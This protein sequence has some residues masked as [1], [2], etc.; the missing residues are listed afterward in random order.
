MKLT[1][2]DSAITTETVAL[3]G[4]SFTELR[5]VND[6][7]F[8]NCLDPAN[9]GKSCVLELVGVQQEGIKSGSVNTKAVTPRDANVRSAVHEYG[10][11]SFLPLV[12]LGDGEVKILYTDYS[13]QHRLF[14]STALDDS[15]T[16]EP[17]VPISTPP[18]TRFAD[19]FHDKKRCR[20][21]CVMEDHS[22]P[23]PEAV[24]NCIVSISLLDLY[25]EDYTHPNSSNRNMLV[26]AKGNDFYSTPTLSPN[27]LYVAYTTWNH[28]NMPWYTTTIGIQKLDEVTGEPI[29]GHLLTVPSTSPSSVVEPRWW[30]NDTLVYLSDESDWY[31]LYAWDIPTTPD[32]ENSNPPICLWKKDSEFCE[33]HNGYVLLLLKIMLAVTFLHVSLQ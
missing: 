12:L 4:K 16:T 10:G 18:A 19:F 3:S 31:N 5:S 28:P 13:S 25:P 9:K 17:P 21:L 2:I 33:P 11:G 15:T 7:L 32:N 30:T 23:R 1:S 22:D 20:I 14:V 26:V 6:R 29:E 27:G 8:V 24:I